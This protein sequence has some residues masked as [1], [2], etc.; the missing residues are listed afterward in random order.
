MIL[1]YSSPP[2]NGYT[3]LIRKDC[4]GLFGVHGVC[5]RPL[6][7]CDYFVTDLFQGPTCVAVDVI[8]RNM[9]ISN[10]SVSGAEINSDYELRFRRRSVP[11]TVSSKPPKPRLKVLIFY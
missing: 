11:C 1:L 9:G 10:S 4:W 3:V 6:L 8:S 7:Y 2:R 5:M